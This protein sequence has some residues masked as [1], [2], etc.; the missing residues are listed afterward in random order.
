MSRKTAL[1]AVT[2]QT[3]VLL[4]N[5]RGE[6]TQPAN[7]NASQDTRKVLNYLYNLPKREEN[8]IV[9]GH[10]AGGSVG[11]TAPKGQDGGYRFKIDEIEYLCPKAQASVVHAVALSRAR[12]ASP[13]VVGRQSLLWWRVFEGDMAKPRLA[14]AQNPGRLARHIGQSVP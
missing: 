2:I 1:L 13:M 5:A 11:P 14:P 9:S 10:L 7:P 3:V 4:I 12:Q 6:N 8:R